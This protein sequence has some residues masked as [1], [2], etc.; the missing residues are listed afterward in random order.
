MEEQTNNNKFDNRPLYNEKEIKDYRKR[1]VKY[2]AQTVPGE[3][4]LIIVDGKECALKSAQ[5]LPYLDMISGI[6]VANVGHSHP[7]VVDAVKKQMD[8]FAHVNVYGK[9][10]LTPQVDIAERLASVSPGD[11]NVSFLTSSGTEA[12]DCLLYTSPSPRD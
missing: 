2:L 10:T 5:G 3:K 12:N 4:E 9:F 1:F 7:A 6:A 8:K 11:L